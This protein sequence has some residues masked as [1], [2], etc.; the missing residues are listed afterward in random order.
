MGAMSEKRHEKDLANNLEFMC[1]CATYKV[2]GSKQITKILITETQKIS[3]MLVE[4]QPMLFS[5]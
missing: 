1:N 5:K 2:E 3:L 4:K